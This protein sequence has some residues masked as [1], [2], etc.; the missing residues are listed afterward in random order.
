MAVDQRVVRFEQHLVV[1]RS[2]QPP[3]SV[4]E[5]DVL[6]PVRLVAKLIA[7]QP[8]GRAQALEALARLVDGRAE[9]LVGI[10]VEPLDRHVELAAGDAAH[11]V[12]HPLA[13]T[14]PKPALVLHGES[15]HSRYCALRSYPRADAEF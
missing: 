9:V 8:H 3:A 4:A 14:Q 10:A 11:S 7:G 12:W 5:G 15:F 2:A 6:A 13:F 1:A